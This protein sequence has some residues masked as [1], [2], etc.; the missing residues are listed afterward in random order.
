MEQEFEWLES[1]IGDEINAG[2]N[3][4]IKKR[5]EKDTDSSLIPLNLTV[6]NIQ[7]VKR[8]F[9]VNIKCSFNQKD[10]LI[11]WKIKLKNDYNLSP[12]DN[13]EINEDF[14]IEGNKSRDLNL[15]IDTPRGGYMNDSLTVNLTINSEDGINK[16]NKIFKVILRPVIIIAKCTI[17]KELDIAIDLSNHGEKDRDDRKKS[18]PNAENEIMA[19]MSPYEIKGYFFIE[20]MHVDRVELLARQIRGFKGLVSGEIDISEIEKYLTPKPAVTGLEMGALVEI[21]EGPFKGERA[22][23]TSIDAAREEVTVQLIESMVP[24]PVTVKAEA[25]RNL[26]K[27]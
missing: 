8:K 16:Y 12:K 21:V 4:K 20:T 9:N 15:E 27:A 13:K 6:K 7:N 23:I 24:I 18:N 26:D 22:K 5:E 25:I 10:P 14:D 1:N 2:C 3:K 11:E 19:I 17:G